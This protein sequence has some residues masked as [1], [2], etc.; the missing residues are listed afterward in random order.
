MFASALWLT[1]RV[2]VK[3]SP[4]VIGSFYTKTMCHVIKNNSLLTQ[5][6]KALHKPVEN[7]YYFKKGTIKDG[8]IIKMVKVPCRPGKRKSWRKLF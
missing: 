1:Q 6:Q 4:N 8:Y 2:I 3:T 7:P 5:S